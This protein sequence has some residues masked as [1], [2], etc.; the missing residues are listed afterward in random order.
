MYVK[1]ELSAVGCQDLFDCIK[2]PATS[3]AAFKQ[4]FLARHQAIRESVDLVIPSV[5]SY[6][7]LKTVV[8]LEP[9]LSWT[10]NKRQRTF[11]LTMFR[12]GLLLQSLSTKSG[13]F[14]VKSLGNCDCDGVSEQTVAHFLFFVATLPFPEK[15]FWWLC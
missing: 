13:W 12:F 2:Q 3:I 7:A 5:T 14:D 10:C 1:T 15:S 11:I 8:G 6:I 9:Y 4:L